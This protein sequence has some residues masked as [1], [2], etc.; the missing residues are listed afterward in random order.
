MGCQSFF[1][2]LWTATEDGALDRFHA[3]DRCAASGH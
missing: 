2:L 3:G 1:K